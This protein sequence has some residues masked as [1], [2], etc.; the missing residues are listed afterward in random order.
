MESLIDSYPLYSQIDE[1]LYE[2]GQLYEKEAATMRKREIKRSSQ[3]KNGRNVSAE[4][5]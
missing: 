4:S 3:G 1:A 2:L 5:Y